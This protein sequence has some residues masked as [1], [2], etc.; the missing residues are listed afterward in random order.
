ML[1]DD[2]GQRLERVTSWGFHTGLHNS[3]P[4]HLSAYQLRSNWLLSWGESKD[5][6]LCNMNLGSPRKSE[7]LLEGVEGGIRRL[8][9]VSS[10]KGMRKILVNVG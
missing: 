3:L 2:T 8:G 10:L 6:Q 1:A 7:C 5:P 9:T 4:G